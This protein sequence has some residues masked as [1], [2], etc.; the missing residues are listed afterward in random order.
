[1]FLYM[2]TTE[3]ADMD[4]RSTAT[5][6]PDKKIFMPTILM[7]VI[8][9]VIFGLA[10]SAIQHNAAAFSLH[11]NVYGLILVAST[12]LDFS[13]IVLIL[14][15]NKRST[16]NVWFLLAIGAMA[17]DGLSEFL[18]SF[19]VHVAGAAFWS[20]LSAVGPPIAFAG[21][22]LFVNEYTG[23][24]RRSSTLL[25]P[26]L[27]LGAGIISFFSSSSTVIY[28]TTY[29]LY[30]F[31]Y[32]NGVSNPGFTLYVI[33]SVA[34]FIAAMA[35]LYRYHQV[36]QEDILKKQARYLMLAILIPNSIA[37][38]TDVLLPVFAFSTSHR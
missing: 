30:A 19:S 28:D 5:P 17:L 10:F 21:L 26:V 24:S 13:L 15:V 38:V 4:E 33:Y 3:A 35:T 34:F 37:L 25:I 29:H 31:G 12:L 7:V 16:D 23:R 6:S 8:A 11:F 2:L 32:D 1:M 22:F 14:R 9:A 20:N 36:A 27:V 18:Q